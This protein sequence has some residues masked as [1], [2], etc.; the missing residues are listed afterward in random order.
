MIDRRTR[1]P[2]L[3]FATCLSCPVL[4]QENSGQAP[5]SHAAT[6][7]EKQ[8][9]SCHNIGGGDKKGPDL[10]NLLQRRDRK[11]AQQFILTPMDLF[12]KGD[13]TAVQ[14]FNKYAPE[15]MPD[16]MLSP[17]QIE[18]IFELIEG[19]SKRKK[20]FVPTSGRLARRPTAGDIP[21][22]ERLF[23]GESRLKKGGSACISCHS[24]TG[25]GYL[26]GGMLG[27][28]LT[29]V[30]RR[31]AE[32]ELASILKAPAFP[33]MSRMYGKHALSDEEVVRIYAYLYSVRDRAPDGTRATSSY[34][35]WGAAGMLAV[36]G[37][38]SFV[39]RG[40]LHGSKE[41]RR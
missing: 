22:G 38:M 1:V 34:L 24:V 12:N 7:Y 37:M 11:W 23:T 3:L 30:C 21:S 29:D 36:F 19:L 41:E 4:A 20:K 40:R 33:T 26:G 8:C 31:Y 17:D 18:E 14:L 28:D 15:Q 2:W 32:V 9:Y 25:I 13:R 10:M 16:Q 35:G 39:W 27:P 5:E 6:L